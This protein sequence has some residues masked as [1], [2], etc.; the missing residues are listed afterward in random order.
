M[1]IC[2]DI[3]DTIANWF[4]SYIS[5]F[6]NPKSSYEIT[7]NVRKLRYN[8][9]FWESLPVLERINFEPH[10]YC[11]KR[12]NPKSYTRNWL[13]NNNFPIKPIYQMYYQKGNKATLIK[14]RC[15]VLI[16]DSIDNV[17]QAINSGLPSLLIDR[18][19]NQTEVP[20]F[21]IYSLDIDEIKF[22]YEL[23]LKTLGWN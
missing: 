3:D 2:L 7:K 21:R 6:G 23:E 20:L 13:I 18:E 17:L 1:R 8:K 4:D 10:C 19:H 22:A 16:D 5:I 9:A 14:G 11:T 15:D 12:I